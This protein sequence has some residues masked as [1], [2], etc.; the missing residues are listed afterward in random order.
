MKRTS[1][2]RNQE[3][4]ARAWRAYCHAMKDAGQ[5]ITMH[6]Q[7]GDAYAEALKDVR[8]RWRYEHRLEVVSALH[9]LTAAHIEEILRDMGEYSD[10]HTRLGG[11]LE[12]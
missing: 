1:T 12:G 10:H 8:A 6:M 5:D 4:T 3:G 11:S 2:Q 9:G 7:A